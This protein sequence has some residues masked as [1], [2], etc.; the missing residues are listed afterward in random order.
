MAKSYNKSSKGHLG[1]LLTFVKTD[2]L[3][4]NIAIQSES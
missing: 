1:F 3:S 4:I 2:T